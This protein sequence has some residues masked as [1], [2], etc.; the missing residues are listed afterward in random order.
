MNLDNKT[1][2]K[3]PCF[4][5]TW[6]LAPYICY[7]TVK[8]H[9]VNTYK[10]YSVEDKNYKVDLTDRDII[11]HEELGSVN[12]NGKRR[13]LRSYTQ[14]NHYMVESYQD[15]VTDQIKNKQTFLDLLHEWKVKIK[16]NKGGN[17]SDLEYASKVMQ[18]MTEE[19]IVFGFQKGLISL[20]LTY[21]LVRFGMVNEMVT[22]YIK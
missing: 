21:R 20:D 6:Y 8:E 22:N 18:K 13:T 2:F 12:E 5:D 4:T 1:V 15:C 11:S 7:K 16:K 19:T 10:C 9:G 17:E 3:K 14:T